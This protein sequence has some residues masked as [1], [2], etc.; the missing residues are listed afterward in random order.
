MMYIC[1]K[2]VEVDE[3]QKEVEKL[4][5]GLEV[6]NY[7]HSKSIVAPKDSIFSFI[8]NNFFEAIISID[9]CSQRE[10]SSF[11]GGSDDLYVKE[12]WEIIHDIGLK[13]ETLESDLSTYLS[14]QLDVKNKLFTLD[15]GTLED[16]LYQNKWLKFIDSISH[17]KRFFN[18]EVSHFLDDLFSVIHD[19]NHVHDSICTVLEPNESLFR[20]R[21]ANSKIERESIITDPANQ[22]GAVPAKLASDQRMTPNG[23]SAFYASSDRETCFSEVRAITG[24]LVISGEFTVNHPL[25]FLDLRKV[26]EL[27][28]K[29]HHPFEHDFLKKS[30]K[31]QFL[32]RLMFLLSKPASKRKNSN[33][34]ETQVIFEYFRVN[35][36]SDISGLI[37][38]S[39]QTGLDGLNV[40][41]FPEKSNVNS[42]TYNKERKI[43]FRESHHQDDSFYSYSLKFVEKLPV[44]ESQANLSFVRDSLE[45]HYIEAVKTIARKQHILVLDDFDFENIDF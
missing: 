14:E 38:S 36:G 15:D 44:Q 9:E 20:A 22:L 4:N 6:C 32:K 18:F 13:N 31:S 29:D 2:C 28:K 34:L 7:C 12:I 21:I 41:L 11:L 27:S 37:F 17:G 39:V 40:V 25:K 1:K 30:H 23:I 8:E 5:I 16:N 33:Y 24:D 42:F 19:N 35:F 26:E 43:V 45:L 3:V 10:S